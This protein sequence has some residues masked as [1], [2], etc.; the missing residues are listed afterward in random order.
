MK[1]L[2]FAAFAVVPLLFGCATHD[3]SAGLPR[4]VNT[5]WDADL[6]FVVAS[7]GGDP[8]NVLLT[9]PNEP[10]VAIPR[11]LLPQVKARFG[12]DLQTAFVG[13]TIH[14]HGRVRSEMLPSADRPAGPVRGL[15][16]IVVSKADQVEL[17]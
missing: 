5:G 4:S 11:R 6:T 8:Q 1:K 2:T 16:R 9:A 7:V 3:P 13:K 12:D 15:A 14:V 17:I 10:S